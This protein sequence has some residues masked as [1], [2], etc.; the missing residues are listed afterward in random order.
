MRNMAAGSPVSPRA[1]FCAAMV[2]AAA[3]QLPA[4]LDSLSFNDTLA[5]RPVAA[6]AFFDSF[7]A[8]LMLEAEWDAAAEVLAREQQAGPRMLPVASSWRADAYFTRCASSSLLA[9]L[10]LHAH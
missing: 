2:S 10:A 8:S 6:V 9:E 1:A 7:G 4:A 5:T 3:A